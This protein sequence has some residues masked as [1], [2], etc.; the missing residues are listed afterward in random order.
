M[1][2][3]LKGRKKLGAS[4][5]EIRVSPFSL[6]RLMLFGPRKVIGCAIAAVIMVVLLVVVIGAGIFFSIQRHQWLATLTAEAPAQVLEVKVV[7]RDRNRNQNINRPS[8]PTYSTRITYRFQANGR[9]I[10][11]EWTKSDDVSDEYTVGGRAKVC[12]NPSNP[13]ENEIFTLSYRCGQ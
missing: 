4:N 9:T 8:S 1:I 10:E 13:D 3:A 7:S 11:T 12:Y 5:V 6:G 2:P